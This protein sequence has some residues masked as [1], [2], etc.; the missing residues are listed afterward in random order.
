L[1]DEDRRRHGETEQHTEQQ[2]HDDIRVAHR[3]Q[4]GLPEELAHPNGVDRSI[5]RLQNI[6]GQDGQ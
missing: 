4:C 5:D 3:R 2:E 1:R 6:A